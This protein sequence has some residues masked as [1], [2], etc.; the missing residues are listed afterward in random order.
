MRQYRLFYQLLII[1]LCAYNSN[2]NLFKNTIVCLTLLLLNVPR[3]LN[4]H[5]GLLR[6]DIPPRSYYCQFT[7]Y[8]YFNGTSFRINH[9]K[10]M[11]L[12]TLRIKCSSLSAPKDWIFLS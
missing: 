7:S 11:T 1:V 2:Y 12:Q 4:P 3:I 9:L 6:F 5:P 8:C 10:L